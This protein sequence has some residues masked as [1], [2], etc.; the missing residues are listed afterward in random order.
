MARRMSSGTVVRRAALYQKL[1]RCGVQFLAVVAN[2]T[3]QFARLGARYG[4]LP[5][6]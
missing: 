1:R 6:K 5:C 3:D 2:A 4:M